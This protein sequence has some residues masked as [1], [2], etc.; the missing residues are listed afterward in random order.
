M[1][2]VQHIYIKVCKENKLL[3][4]LPY[5]L[6]QGENILKARNPY[7]NASLDLS[8]VSLQGTI[9]KKSSQETVFPLAGITLQSSFYQTKIP[10]QPFK[11]NFSGSIFLTHIFSMAHTKFLPH[12]GRTRTNVKASYHTIRGIC[13]AASLSHPKMDMHLIQQQICSRHTLHIP[14]K[15]Y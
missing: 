4:I 14:E 15:H 7:A 10:A 2:E 1:Y 13:W 11:L 9:Q 8:F 6:E 5:S 3:S 12:Y